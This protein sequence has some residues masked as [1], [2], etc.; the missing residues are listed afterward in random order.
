MVDQ[1]SGFALSKVMCAI[2][3]DAVLDV[4]DAYAIHLVAGYLGLGLQSLGGICRCPLSHHEP[5]RHR[6]LHPKSPLIFWIGY[7]KFHL[8]WIPPG[9]IGVGC[10][11]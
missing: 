2:R 7:H 1:G 11:I 8:L 3:I 9:A 10:Q 5:S 6:G 4:R